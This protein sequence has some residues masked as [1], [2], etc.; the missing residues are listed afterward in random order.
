MI[1]T[2]EVIINVNHKHKKR[3]ADLGYDITQK[4][5]LVKIEDVAKCSSVVID[6]ICDVCNKNKKSTLLSY[7]TSMNKGGYY[8]C[9]QKCSR[10]KV[11]NTNIE[12]YGV[13]TPAKNNDIVDKM[14]ST[15]LE[16]Y[17]VENSMYVEKF[18]QKIKKTNLERYGVESSLQSDATKNKIKITNLERYGVENPSQSNI[19]KDRKK[20]TSMKNYNVEYPCQDLNIFNKQQMSCFLLKE[21][22]GFKYRGTYE[23]DF[24]IFCIKNNISIKNSKNR[25]E[26]YTDKKHY[27]FP[28]FYL[29]ELNLI[30]EI[31]SK[32]TYK[33]NLEVNLAKQQA[34]INNGFDYIFII[35]KEYTDFLNKIK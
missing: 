30:I 9:S 26:Y 15:N 6:V 24:I 20:E 33:K 35:D 23:L 28:D 7:N 22:N 2:K 8:A 4:T 14:K 31:K 12:R 21:Y 19:I 16:R 25:I 1:I 32:Y 5:M 27:Y 13:T 3:Y 29:E 34:T 17:G 11:E 10:L 18:K